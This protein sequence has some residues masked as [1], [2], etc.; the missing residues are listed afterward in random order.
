MIQDRR[1]RVN[2]ALS[3]VQNV[4]NFRWTYGRQRIDVAGAPVETGNGGFQ[5]R[6]MGIPVRPMV[7][8]RY[9]ISALHL[10]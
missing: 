4:R 5:A 7:L 10:L 3:H 2:A 6:N 9:A 8:L 1:I